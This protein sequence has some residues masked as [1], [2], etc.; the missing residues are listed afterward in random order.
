MIRGSIRTLCLLLVL[1]VL[2]AGW[3]VRS[4]SAASV[5]SPKSYYL[6]LGDSLAFGYQPNFDWSHGYAQDLYANLRTHGATSSVNYGCAGETAYTFIHGGCPYHNFLMLHNYYSGTQLSAAVNFIKAHPGKVSPVTI[7]IGANDLKSLINTSTCA[8]SDYTGPLATFDSNFKYIL[9]QLASA[10]AGKGTIVVM[11]YYDPYQ[12]SCPNTVPLV[13]TFNSHI[14]SD[15]AAV[16]SAQS[17]VIPVADV[18]TAFGGPASPN[19]TIC[20]DT[21]MCSS[22]N[23]IHANDAGYSV[24]AGAFESAYGY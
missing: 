10:L 20:S 6:A 21:W 4:A 1:A 17:T 5:V 15:S 22:Y 12:N 2:P 24:I 11:N 8:V 9:T 16:A 3:S 13:Q 19:S 18:F 7:D 23:D 14:A